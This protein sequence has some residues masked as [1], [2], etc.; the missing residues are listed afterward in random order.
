MPTI[1]D[2]AKACGMAKSTVSR[3][4]NNSQGNVSARTR[5]HVMK[6]VRE[7]NFQPSA[8]AQGLSKQRSNMIGIVTRNANHL[9]TDG[10]YGS[11]INGIADAA[12]AANQVVALYQ[13]VIW[14]DEAKTQLTLV[15][16]WCDGFLILMAN[17]DA[18]L[19]SALLAHG[20]PFLYVNSGDLVDGIMS[21]DI[22]NADAGY[23]MTRHL[24]EHGHRRIACIHTGVDQFSIER[25]DGYKRALQEAGIECDERLVVTAFY[26][27]EI[28]G[29]E[30]AQELLR[31]TSLGITAIFAATD[32]LATDAVYGAKD[33]GFHV[34]DDISVVGINDTAEALRCNPPLTTLSQSVEELGVNAVNVLLDRIARPTQPSRHITW[35]TRL[36]ER[37]TVAP[38]KN[39]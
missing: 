4:I 20:I 13:G 5:E 26:K 29:Y 37:E 27:P 38:P 22:D 23:K 19:S 11:V 9:L 24:I 28:S 15:N 33:M 35:P 2:V 14:K 3:V 10:Y 39:R 1:E 21:I 32:V 12:A 16:G 6:V 31:N 25:R 34:P 18:A 8:M 30:R 7:M 17:Q 36:V